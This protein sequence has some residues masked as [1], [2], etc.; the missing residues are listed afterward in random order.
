MRLSPGVR[1]CFLKIM[2]TVIIFEILKRKKYFSRDIN[3]RMLRKS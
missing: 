2:F 3:D 1:A